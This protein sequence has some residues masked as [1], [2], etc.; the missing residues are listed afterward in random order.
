MAY[1]QKLSV[2]HLYRLVLKAKEQTE[3]DEIYKLYIAVYPMFDKKT[4]QSFNEFQEQFKPKV[5]YNETR[6]TDD[7]MN[8]LL[9]GK[10][11]K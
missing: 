2:C 8:E 10:G 9:N 3:R 6:S 11:V 7:L 5:K 4:F 1:I